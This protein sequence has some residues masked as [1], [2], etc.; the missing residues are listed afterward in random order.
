LWD[1]ENNVT[2][3]GPNL[4]L[5]Q[6]VEACLH[7]QICPVNID[8]AEKKAKSLEY[9]FEKGHFALKPSGIRYEGQGMAQERW[10]FEFNQKPGQHSLIESFQLFININDSSSATL[11]DQEGQNQD[12]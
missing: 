9:P 7:P 3:Y 12:A 10:S 2:S 11:F 5:Q 1:L 4:R 8:S 6:L